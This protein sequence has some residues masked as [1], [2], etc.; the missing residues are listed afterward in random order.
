MIAGRIPGRTDKE[1]KNYWNTH[2]SKRSSSD[3]ELLEHHKP[4]INPKNQ[5]NEK[6]LIPS[7]QSHQAKAIRP[8]PFKCTKVDVG[9]PSHLQDDQDH[10]IMVDTTVPAGSSSNND[11]LILDLLNS[12]EF[13]Q[14]QMKDWQVAMVE[15]Y[16]R[17][18][19]IIA[20]VD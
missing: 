5:H 19:P 4:S 12:T 7:D 6:G 9:I 11:L 17:G 8:K 20:A 13:Q 10:Q 18:S 2:L 14:V 15:N 16:W 1:I 3:Q